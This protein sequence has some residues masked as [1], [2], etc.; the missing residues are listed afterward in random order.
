MK[1]VL[2]RG[3]GV[4]ESECGLRKASENKIAPSGGVMREWAGYSNEDSRTN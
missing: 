3:K 1:F 2:E 4:D